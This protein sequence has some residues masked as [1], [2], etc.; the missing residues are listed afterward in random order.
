[1]PRPPLWRV[2]SQPL[3]AAH[4]RFRADGFDP[5][6][7]GGDEVE[8]LAD[9]L[10]PDPGDR[11]WRQVEIV[12]VVPKIVCTIKMPSAWWRKA[13]C[14]KSAMIIFDSSNQS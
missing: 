8:V 14:R 13:R 9:V 12:T 10:L 5:I 4:P 3:G 2:V 11:I 1:M 7:E 6:G